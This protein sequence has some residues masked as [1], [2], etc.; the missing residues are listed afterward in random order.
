MGA[1]AEGLTPNAVER[2]NFIGAIGSGVVGL[3]AGSAPSSAKALKTGTASVFTGDYDDPNHP[4]CLRQVKVVGAPLKG[5]GTRSAYPVVEVV[6]WDGREGAKT[7]TPVDR[8]TREELWKIEGSL[9]SNKEAVIDFSPKG[10]P[11]NLVAT[12]D[13]GI[14]FPDGNKWTK[15]RY[16]ADRRPKDM[17]TLKSLD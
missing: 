8:P 4:G 1:M 15:V 16:Q 7:C 2:R 10:G 12:F 3:I 11:S 14:V 6:G 5:D 13:D 17:S 9:R